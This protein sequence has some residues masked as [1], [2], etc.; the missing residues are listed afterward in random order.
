M[1]TCTRCERDIDGDEVLGRYDTGGHFVATPFGSAFHAACTTTLPWRT[2]V[3]GRV[4]VGAYTARHAYAEAEEPDTVTYVGP[5][6][7]YT[8]IRT[9][10]A[11]DRNALLMALNDAYEQGREDARR[12]L[13]AALGVRS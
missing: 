13:R 7:R 2:P 12:E 3:T 4:T 6:Q 9:W 10:N 8:H 5:G 11:A 1:T